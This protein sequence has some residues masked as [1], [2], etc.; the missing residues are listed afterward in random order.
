MRRRTFVAASLAGLLAPTLVRAQTTAATTPTTPPRERLDIE[1]ANELERTFI[2]ALQHEESRPA[3]RRELLE[4][5]VALA[6]SSTSPDAPPRQIELR[7]GQWACLIFTS[8]ARAAQ[9]M[10]P[11]SPRVVLSGREALTRVRGANVIIN[12]NLSPSLVLEAEDV[13]DYLE[14][15]QAAR[16]LPRMRPPAPSGAA[17]PTQ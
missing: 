17:G 7:S 9:V 16:P 10:G 13:D 5:D 15:P 11:A 2:E 14:I 8:S 6:L 3:F 4:S 1:P 12:I